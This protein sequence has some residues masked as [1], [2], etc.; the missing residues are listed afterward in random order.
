MVI[1]RKE[2]KGNGYKVSS[3]FIKAVNTDL[4]AAYLQ[5][6]NTTFIE[7]AI[8]NDF[9]RTYCREWK[10][11]EPIT[12]CGEPRITTE[13]Q[14]DFA[15][16]WLAKTLELRKDDSLIDQ[17]LKSYRQTIFSTAYYQIA[18]HSPDFFSY[19][20]TLAEQSHIKMYFR[21]NTTVKPTYKKDKNGVIT[22]T[23]SVQAG[24]EDLH[25]KNSF[26]F[27]TIKHVFIFQNKEPA[28]FYLQEMTSENKKLLELVTGEN[29]PTAA[30][31][32]AFFWELAQYKLSKSLSLTCF[33]TEKLSA[34]AAF[35]ERLY[36]ADSDSS[37]VS[38][39]GERSN[40]LEYLHTKSCGAN[41][42][43]A[44]EYWSLR[45]WSTRITRLNQNVSAR[46][47]KSSEKEMSTP[48]Q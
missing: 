17:I 30:Q 46:T 33:P 25:K 21:L 42:V 44:S 1:M 39:V 26:S 24:F 31:S 15:K 37:T 43:A 18:H 12:I 7:N 36:F 35:S 23:F 29:T 2:Q 28:G 27:G 32:S 40:E 47:K 16:K 20:K 45:F 4:R 22:L 11:D 48:R 14:T 5:P 3:N 10:K 9:N 38:S 13:T 6:S 19:M 8:R 41:T 34:L